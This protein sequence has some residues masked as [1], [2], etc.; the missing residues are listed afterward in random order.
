L[1]YKSA[2]YFSPKAHVSF[3]KEE[4]KKKTNAALSLSLS[5]LNPKS[6]QTKC[7]KAA[8]RTV[9]LSPKIDS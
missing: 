2:A 4:S 7:L 9:E 3:K 5:K 6:L 8:T 1:L